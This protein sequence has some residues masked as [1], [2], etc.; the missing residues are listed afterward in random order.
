MFNR[1]SSWAFTRMI[2][3]GLILLVSVTHEHRLLVNGVLLFGVVLNLPIFYD[4]F[5]YSNNRSL[6]KAKSGSKKCTIVNKRTSLT[7][8][9]SLELY[10]LLLLQ[11]IPSSVFQS[12]SRE[13]II[14]FQL[15]CLGASRR[16]TPRLPGCEALDWRWAQARW[17]LVRWKNEGKSVCL[18]LHWWHILSHSVIR[19]QIG[20]C[21]STAKN[22]GFLRK[23][24]Y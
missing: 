22:C 20:N 9:E 7:K 6:A 10:C 15:H 24:C 4:R 21:Q 2:V 17:S 8:L 5:R 18:L 1:N 19:S 11:L 14:I 16:S 23:Q 13:L 12:K 3:T